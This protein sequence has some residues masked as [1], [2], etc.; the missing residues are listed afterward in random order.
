ME[1]IVTEALKM[2]NSCHTAKPA[3][4][5]GLNNATKDKL[6]TICKKCRTEHRRVARMADRMAAVV[7]PLA[8]RIAESK[9]EGDRYRK[10]ASEST[11][12]SGPAADAL[13]RYYDRQS[14]V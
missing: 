9:E 11:I 2:C 6:Q 12:R 1:A 8:E 4:A 10:L 7:K 3:S 14:V 5:F 13:E